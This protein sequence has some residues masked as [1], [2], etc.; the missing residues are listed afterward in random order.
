[1][2]L[3]HTLCIIV[4]LQFFAGHVDADDSAT[5]LRAQTLLAEKKWEELDALLDP[6]LVEANPHLEALFLSGMAARERGDYDTAAKRFR[7]MLTRDPRLLRPRLELARTFQLAGDRQAAIYNYEQVLSADLPDTVRR[8]IYVQLNAIRLREPSFRFT[9]EVVS[10]TNPQ[11]T[12][13]SKVVFIGGRPYTLNTT[14]EGKLQWGI[15]A[16][17]SGIYPIP[18]DPSWFIQFFGQV[19]E[20]PN[21][22]LDNAYA[23]TTLGK[24]MIF[25]TNEVTLSLGGQLATNKGEEQYV[26]MVSRATGLFT[27]SPKL[28]FRGDLSVN[29]YRYQDLQYLD[30]ELGTLGVTA[31]YVPNPTQRFEIGGFFASYSAAEDPYSYRQPG[32]NIYTSREWNQGWITG[33]RLLA[34]ESRYSAPDPFFGETRKDKEGRLELSIGN[35]KLIWRDMTPLLTV[36]Y[37]QRDSTLDV[38]TYNRFYARVGIT[39]L[40]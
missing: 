12:P 22:N 24:R 25:G 9:A 26:G 16:T 8:N 3:L 32:I 23:Q 30:G 19:Y 10:D 31:I 13:S 11:Q 17:G 29:T 18:I 35:R 39:T 28:F 4:G 27:A 1:M 20:Y 21:R 5:L 36:G 14:T 40:F 38:N 2:K 15:A 6:F 34:S 7:A 33:L 37:V